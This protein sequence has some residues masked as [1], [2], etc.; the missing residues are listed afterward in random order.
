MPLPF[1]AM[2]SAAHG[3]ILGRARLYLESG[4]IQAQGP[5]DGALSNSIKDGV[6]KLTK[7]SVFGEAK[8]EDLT[9]W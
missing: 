8:V 6:G 9:A 3:L 7:S 2:G 4:R 5:L 1:W